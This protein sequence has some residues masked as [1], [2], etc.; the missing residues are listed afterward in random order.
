MY[1]VDEPFE[2]ESF[3]LVGQN[4]RLAHC[5]FCYRAPTRTERILVRSPGKPREITPGPVRVT[6]VLRAEPGGADPLALDLETFEVLT[7]P[8]ARE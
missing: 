1:A 8:P 4:P 7:G 2:A 5:P 3:Y 6:G